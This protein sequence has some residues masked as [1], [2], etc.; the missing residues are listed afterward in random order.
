MV[1][2]I[3]APKK[4]SVGRKAIDWLSNNAGKIIVGLDI[5]AGAF[6]IGSIGYNKGCKRTANAYDTTID[7]LDKSGLIK[8]HHL[9]GTEVNYDSVTD[10]TKWWNEAD[11][12]VKPKKV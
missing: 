2:T 8:A 6:F 5:I 7:A 10:K 11:M 9:D 12:V 3:K 4:K 1:E